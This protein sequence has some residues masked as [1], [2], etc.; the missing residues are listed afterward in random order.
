M[1]GRCLSILMER[2]GLSLPELAKNS[3]L[4]EGTLRNLIHDY[5]SSQPTLTTMAKLGSALGVDVGVIARAAT[6]ATPEQ[7]KKFIN[8]AI[9]LRK[10]LSEVVLPDSLR[11]E[12]EGRLEDLVND[13]REAAA[14]DPNMSLEKMVLDLLDREGVAP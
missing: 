14:A 13:V 2:R 1:L 12:Y 10:L 4:A 11:I 5:G 8:L 9:E 6:L 7:Q 3:G